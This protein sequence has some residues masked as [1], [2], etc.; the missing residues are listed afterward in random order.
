[1]YSTSIAMCV[2]VLIKLHVAFA[3]CDLILEK[4]ALYAFGWIYS[5]TIL[6]M[7]VLAVLSISVISSHG[8]Q[9]TL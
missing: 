5:G 9:N 6:A 8:W 4:Y 7:V 2:L 1:M 3:F